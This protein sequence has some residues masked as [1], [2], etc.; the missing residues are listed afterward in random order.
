M[1]H[2]NFHILQSVDCHTHAS[3]FAGRELRVGIVSHLCGKIEGHRQTRLTF[4]KEVAKAFVGFASGSESCVLTHGPKAPTILIG[5]HAAQEWGLAGPS[6]FGFGVE[7]GQ[8]VRTIKRF[9][10]T[11][12]LCAE[13]VFTL[14]EFAQVGRESAALP[15]L[16]TAHASS[17]MM[18]TRAALV[19]TICP[20]LT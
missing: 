12:R 19:S 11:T 5:L 18:R 4:F 14:A 13:W 6:Q 17:R 10:L 2:E 20:S 3:H 9:N 7:A 15:V 1:I 16:A 8:V